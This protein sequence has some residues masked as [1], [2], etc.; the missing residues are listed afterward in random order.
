MI[1]T[2]SIFAVSF[3]V[4]AVMI[5]M[6]TIELKQKRAFA[7]T[8]FLNKVDAT[9]EVKLKTIKSDFL[10]KKQEVSFFVTH[11]IPFYVWNKA[12]DL[13]AGIRQKYEKIEHAVR[14]RN[15]I[16]QAGEV[17]EYMKNISE[18]KNSD[19]VASVEPVGHPDFTENTTEDKI[20]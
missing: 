20:N 10:K 12:R 14:G 16:K 7:P 13:T 1:I 11:H 17:S 15:M 4:C 18:Y 6:R 5:I 19:P 2:L 3:V 8:D 9:L